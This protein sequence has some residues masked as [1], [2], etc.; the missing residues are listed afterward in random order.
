MVLDTILTEIVRLC[1]IILAATLLFG[2]WIKRAEG[3]KR[4]VLF[5]FFITILVYGAARMGYLLYLINPAY[6]WVTAISWIISLAIEIW[7]VRITFITFK[8]KE[9]TSVV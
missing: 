2:I 3:E 4:N 7:V 5:C 9:K 6:W 1:A 8:K